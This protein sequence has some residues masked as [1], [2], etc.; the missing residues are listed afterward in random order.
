MRWEYIAAGLAIL[1]VIG[2]CL[3]I[4]QEEMEQQARKDRAKIN[5]W[6]L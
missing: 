6:H 1:T 2:F 5:Q 4:F 3:A